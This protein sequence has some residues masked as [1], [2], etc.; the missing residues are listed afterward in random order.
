MM[1]SGAGRLLVSV[2]EIVEPKMAYSRAR[3]EEDG[4]LSRCFCKTSHDWVPALSSFE[5]WPKCVM[6]EE[7][8]ELFV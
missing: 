5:H 8:F 1:T 3:V 2:H 4:R 6:P 7:D